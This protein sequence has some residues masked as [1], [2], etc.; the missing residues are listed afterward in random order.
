MGYHDHEDSTQHTIPALMLVRDDLTRLKTTVIGVEYA[1]GFTNPGETNNP[2]QM[3]CWGIYV[4]S[5][6]LDG[7]RH[8]WEISPLK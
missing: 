3:G 1:D 8:P 7:A 4:N 6:Y 2:N 5:Q